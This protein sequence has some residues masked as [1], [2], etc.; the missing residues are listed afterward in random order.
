MQ[1]VTWCC[2]DSPRR[3]LTV[4][5]VELK[6]NTK[7][8]RSLRHHAI[9]PWGNPNLLA[10]R[11]P[12]SGLHGIHAV[13]DKPRA[14]TQSLV[15]RACRK[16]CWHQS[17]TPFNIASTTNI[18]ELDMIGVRGV[19]SQQHENYRTRGAAPLM[20]TTSVCNAMQCNAMLEASCNVQAERLY[21][22]TWTDSMSTLSHGVTGNSRASAC[23]CWVTTHC[24]ALLDRTG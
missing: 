5:R 21:A 10:A 3:V 24:F 22:H 15:C 19:M 14:A 18:I 17:R 16:R 4:T 13:N 11:L 2:G 23:R 20:S 8:S 7:I 6:A 12:S 1:S 9:S